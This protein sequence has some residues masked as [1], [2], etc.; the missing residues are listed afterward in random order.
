MSRRQVVDPK[1]EGSAEEAEPVRWKAGPDFEDI[2]YIDLAT[3]YRDGRSTLSPFTVV[4]DQSPFQPGDV[5]LTPGDDGEPMLARVIEVTIQ[6][7]ASR[8]CAIPK[9]RVQRKTSR[10]AWAR[11]WEYTHPG[12]IQRAYIEAGHSYAD[13]DSAD[14]AGGV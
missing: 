2:Y 7:L 10:G 6:I 8:G 14:W 5:V 12:P 3:A 4:R 11:R 13:P 1:W 9:Y